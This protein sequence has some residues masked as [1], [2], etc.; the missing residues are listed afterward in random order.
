MDTIKKSTN[1]VI[2]LAGGAMSWESHPQ[3]IAVQYTAKK[4]SACETFMEDGEIFTHLMI[5]T[6]QG[7]IRTFVLKL[8]IKLHL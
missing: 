3:S 6:F 2:F 1:Y 7:C 5:E 8:N 4:V